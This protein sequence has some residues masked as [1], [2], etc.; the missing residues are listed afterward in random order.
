MFLIKKSTGGPKRF[1][2][3]TLEELQN[4]YAELESKYKR[5]VLST[6]KKIGSSQK[7]SSFLPVIFFIFT[8]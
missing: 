2:P 1:R 8:S 5:V 7:G 3:K 6:T 4:D